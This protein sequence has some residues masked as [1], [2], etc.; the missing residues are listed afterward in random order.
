MRPA[1]RS[2]HAKNPEIARIPATPTWVAH[3]S[4]WITKDLLE[5]RAIR[6]WAS[7]SAKNRAAC[8]G[9]PR[10]F[11][12]DAE[13]MLLYPT[14]HPAVLLLVGVSLGMSF[15]A[16]EDLDTN[17]GPPGGLAAGQSFPTPAENDSGGGG[18]TTKPDGGSMKKCVFKAPKDSGA[19]EAS[20]PTDAESEG[21]A[22]AEDAGAPD[23]GT[24]AEDTGA[25]DAGAPVVTDG[26]KVSWTRDIYPNM[27]A[28]GKWA[29]G[30][31]AC[32]GGGGFS[33]TLMGNAESF[34]DTLIST[35]VTTGTGGDEML[36]FLLPCATDPSKSGFVCVTST[37]NCGVEMPVTTNGVPATALS[38]S[39]IAMIKTW[40]ACGAQDD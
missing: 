37:S 17:F 6:E 31:V 1:T 19:M 40:I 30:N 16:C 28:G 36:P 25:P 8:P 21:A 11:K 33:P 14:K 7:F 32:H 2:P 12:W 13:M 20:S 24:P 27:T 10:A 26:C 4:D 18:K 39:D 15:A 38:S 3:V 34:Y 5:R 29:C 22:D 35:Q 9:A 23:T